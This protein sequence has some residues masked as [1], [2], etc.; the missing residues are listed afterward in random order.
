[1]SPLRPTLRAALSEDAPWAPIDGLF[2]YPAGLHPRAADRLLALLPDGPVGDPF[3]GGGAVV[4]AAGRAARPSYGRDVSPAALAIAAAR[5]WRPTRAERAAFR[6]AAAGAPAT[7]AIARHLD[8]LRNSSRNV[9]LTPEQV[10]RR[11]ARAVAAWAAAPPLEPPPDLARADARSVRFP[12][13]L[14]GVLTSPPYPGVYDYDRRTTRLRAALGDAPLRDDEIST[15]RAFRADPAAATAAYASDTRAWLA[16]LTPQL[17]PGA[18]VIVVIGDGPG[19]E[20]P[21][22]TASV[23]AAAGRAVGLVV[24]EIV[25]A[26]AFSRPSP[27]REHVIVLDLH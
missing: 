22:D 16:N 21:V 13:A 10:R 5:C 12:E 20:G 14:A 8:T 15:R 24:T 4:Q 3:V 17:R 11:A 23:T 1:M 27:R 2:D 9:A 6:A 7:G 18:R 26:P 19:P 25:T